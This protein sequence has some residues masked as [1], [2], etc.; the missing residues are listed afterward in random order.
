MNSNH[1]DT[2]HQ[3]SRASGGGDR[4]RG[5]NQGGGGD[6]INHNRNRANKERRERSDHNQRSHQRQQKVDDHAFIPTGQETHHSKGT[7]GD[8]RESDT[9]GHITNDVR[10]SIKQRLE[11]NG[12]DSR[13]LDPNL[14][15]NTIRILN[16]LLSANAALQG[17]VVDLSVSASIS[18]QG[19]SNAKRSNPSVEAS[20]DHPNKRHEGATDWAS[21]VEEDIIMG[22]LPTT[23]SSS[24]SS[25]TTYRHDSTTTVTIPGDLRPDPRPPVT[26]P[27]EEHPLPLALRDIGPES[28]ESD[29]ESDISEDES[30]GELDQDGRIRSRQEIDRRVRHNQRSARRRVEQMD[31]IMEWRR[32]AM[33]TY[34]GR[35]PDVWGVIIPSGSIGSPQRDNYLRG[36]LSFRVYYSHLSNT[37]FAGAT[38][39]QAQRFEL[40]NQHT[41]AYRP[42]SHHHVYAKVPL[43]LP[44]NPDEV[45]TLIHIVKS[46]GFPRATR[47]EAHDLL[48]EL[49]AIARSVC[50]ELRDRAMRYIAEFEPQAISLDQSFL[51]GWRFEPIP[52]VYQDGT[53]VTPSG[54]GVRMPDHPQFLMLDVMA[55]YF[56]LHARPDT[57]SPFQGVA[58]DHSFRVNRRTLF[59][60][61]LSRTLAPLD[62]KAARPAFTRNFITVIAHVGLYREAIE[63]YNMANPT[64]PFSPQTGPTY[65][66]KRCATT[67]GEAA[68]IS[69]STIMDTLISNR[70]PIDWVD[71]AYPYAFRYLDQHYS[72]SLMDEDRLGAIDDER[73]RRIARYGEPPAIEGWDGWYHPSRDD[74]TRVWK[75]KENEETSKARA[76]IPLHPHI[77][78]LGER[79]TF[80]YLKDRPKRRMPED[81]LVL[82]DNPGTTIKPIENAHPVTEKAN[83]NAE[84]DPVKI[85]TDANVKVDDPMTD[86]GGVVHVASTMEVISNADS[87]QV[88]LP[89]NDPKA[90]S[91]EAGTPHK[92]DEG[93]SHLE[94]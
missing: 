68:N 21:Q 10:E 85:I 44:T 53:L 46:T 18:S 27:T 71:H 72:G 8:R 9:I 28:G 63:T 25:N 57:P 52:R 17:R 75:L 77:L 7:N 55:R 26:D 37:V 34:V 24:Q 39:I 82:F 84:I 73:L 60:L 62:R 3:S 6:G 32:M 94:S 64:N 78:A 45:E 88:P 42:P 67:D 35:I 1:S 87:A 47:K 20:W 5:V 86:I 33:Q 80:R 89:A 2:R 36:M 56:I 38:A 12:I 90:P 23:N 11:A 13:D 31:R 81:V 51:A 70:I 15:L 74:I 69:T 16:S 49:F 30:T 14:S 61:G 43:G 48:G 65:T 50:A 41:V 22:N 40:S 76:D 91:D 79:L 92:E 83:A 4:H 93:H 58:M 66:F 29:L 59:G 54:L 19:T